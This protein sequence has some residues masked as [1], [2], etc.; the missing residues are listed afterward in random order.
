MDERFDSLLI[1]L[2]QSANGIENFL[3]VIFGF[4]LRKTDFFTAMNQGEEEKIL[5]K[6]FRKYQALSADKRREEKRLMMEREEE[7]KKKIE[8]QKRREEEELKNMST[9]SVPKIEEVFSDDEKG[10][11]ATKTNEK[12]SDEEES[13]T[14]APPL[15]NGGSTDKYT[16]TQTLGT[17]EVLIDTIPGLKSRDCNINIK[18]NRLKVVVKGEVIIDGELNSKVKPDDCLWSIIDGK[19][20]QIVLEKQENINWWSCVIK[21]DQEIDTTKIVP[22]N[23]K[24][25]DL[26]PETRATVEKMMFDQRQKAMGLPTSDNLKQHELLEKFKAAHPEMDFSQAKINY[27]SGF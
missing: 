19:T 4:L 6:Y 14:E 3:D 15:G 11:P 9:K 10:Q 21:G 26:D 5:M 8:E 18:T 23:S 13:D 1:N 16:W 17:V 7:R 24:L 25:S 20:I 2:A 12:M 27:G 22:E